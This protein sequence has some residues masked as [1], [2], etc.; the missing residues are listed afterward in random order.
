MKRRTG[1]RHS[2]FNPSQTE[3]LH[4]L[5]IWIVPREEGLP[6]GYEEKTLDP[7]LLGRRLHVVAAA[8]RGRTPWTIRQDAAIRIGRLRRGTRS[9]IRSPGRHAGSTWRPA[10]SP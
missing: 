1:I 6:P 2:E 8:T 10:K 5:Q 9:R 3:A 7:A 4:F